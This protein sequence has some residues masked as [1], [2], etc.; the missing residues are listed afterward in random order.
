MRCIFFKAQVKFLEVLKTF[1]K[2]AVNFRMLVW[3]TEQLF[4]QTLKN[5]ISFLGPK[6]G[7]CEI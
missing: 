4:E 1:A 5:E 7:T 3:N 2:G 6:V